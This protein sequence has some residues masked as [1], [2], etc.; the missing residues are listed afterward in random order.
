MNNN[1]N[2]KPFGRSLGQSSRVLSCPRHVNNILNPI[3]SGQT[4]D[5][6]ILWRL[7]SQHSLL[8]HKFRWYVR[9]WPWQLDFSHHQDLRSSVGRNSH[10]CAS[11]WLYNSFYGN[12]R[13]RSPRA[14]S[15]FTVEKEEFPGT[16]PPIPRPRRPLLI[17]CQALFAMARS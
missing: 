13:G 16:H 15:I 14:P 6:E 10:S 3:L 12:L 5:S 2:K 8:L 4:E 11:I 1:N 9:T 7:S 17:L